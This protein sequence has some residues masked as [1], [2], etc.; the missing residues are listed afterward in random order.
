MTE[1]TDAHII[2]V[3][4]PSHVTLQTKDLFCTKKEKG[5]PEINR[6]EP[7]VSPKQRRID[8]II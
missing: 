7:I 6:E 2:K 8:Q 3:V 5:S 1:L 4:R